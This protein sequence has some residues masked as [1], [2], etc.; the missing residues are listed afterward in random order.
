M[1]N[2]L[3]DDNGNLRDAYADNQWNLL[4]TNVG[5][6]YDLIIKSV[7]WFGQFHYSNPRK[8]KI[9]NIFINVQRWEIKRNWLKIGNL[10]D[11]Y[12]NNQWN[13][14]I[15]SV[16]KTYDLIIN[17]V[18]QFRQIYYSITR[19]I[20]IGNTFENRSPAKCEIKRNWLQE[21]Q[22]DVNTSTDF[23]IGQIFEIRERAGMYG[24]LDI[25]VAYQI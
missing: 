10:R 16:I 14:L 11:P 24:Y 20:R 9:G 8:I 21:L 2:A 4:I 3:I 13:L 22:P 15:T 17:S 7:L 19:K 25:L 5:K 1:D 12:A 6:T 23:R 18:L